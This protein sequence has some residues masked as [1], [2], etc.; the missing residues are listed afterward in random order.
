MSKY[1]TNCQKLLAPLVGGS[2][3]SYRLLCRKYGAQLTYTEMNIPT[4][5]LATLNDTLKPT[6]K[7]LVYEFDPTDRPLF[8]QVKKKKKKQRKE[9]GLKQLV[10]F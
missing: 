1:L 10:L 6:N 4:H 9:S 2:D 7:T 3:L 8:L 5:Y